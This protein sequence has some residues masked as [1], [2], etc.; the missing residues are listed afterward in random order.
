MGSLFMTVHTAET[1][2]PARAD[3][4][5]LISAPI[6]PSNGLP[7]LDARPPGTYSQSTAG[8]ESYPLQ[9]LDNSS[10][11]PLVANPVDREL[12]SIDNMHSDE[13]EGVY[14]SAEYDSVLKE[15]AHKI[16]QALEARSI[17]PVSSKTRL[18]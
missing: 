3:E 17:T 16:R 9:N 1:A 10:R 5:P 7:E 11:A 2:A 14:G 15:R 18:A 13:E 8:A 6:A 12:R 4:A